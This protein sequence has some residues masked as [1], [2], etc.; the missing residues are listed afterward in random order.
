MPTNE[1]NNDLPNSLPQDARDDRTAAAVVTDEQLDETP[2]GGG[3]GGTAN[4]ADP[5]SGTAAGRTGTAPNAP[6]DVPLPGQAL[7]E[8]GQNP[9]ATRAAQTEAAGEASPKP[10]PLGTTAVGGDR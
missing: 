1:P 3:L 6:I 9:S 10:N 2:G 8:D 5:L 7:D 4:A